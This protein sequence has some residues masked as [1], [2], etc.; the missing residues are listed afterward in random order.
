MHAPWHSISLGDSYGNASGQGHR[1]Y[2][3]R[4]SAT[5]RQGSTPLS[6]PGGRPH[7]RGLALATPARHRPT[8]RALFTAERRLAGTRKRAADNRRYPPFT[9]ELKALPVI[10]IGVPVIEA[11]AEIKKSL[12]SR[13]RGLDDMDRLI[14]ATA[15]SLNYRLVTNTP[16]LPT[17]VV[18]SIMLAL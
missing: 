8:D 7:H 1:R 12:Q 3:L 15:L 6:E 4:K 9:S 13:G 14:A 17:T 5:S 10:G 2:P 11:F 18:C 16:H